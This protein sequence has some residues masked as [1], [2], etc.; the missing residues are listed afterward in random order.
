[1]LY[2]GKAK[3]LNKRVKNYSQ[4]N[5]LTPDKQQ[6]VNQAKQLKFQE[7][8]NEIEA[9]LTEAE[10]IRTYQP[11]FNILL[12]D[13]KSPLYIQITDEK[14][15]RVLQLRKTAL[16][17]A[18]NQRLIF[19][20]FS[21]GFM[22]TQVLKLARKI[23]PWCST[24]ESGKPCFYYHLQLCPGACCDKVTA[25]EYQQNISKL[26][27]FLRGQSQKLVRQLKAEM[28]QQSDLESYEAASRLKQQ[29]E[30]V[31]YVTQ[32]KYRLQPDWQTLALADDS[33][34][35]QLKYLSRL[36]K[37]HLGVPTQYSIERIEGYDVSN[38]SGTDATVSQ[39]TF[40]HGKETPSE[41]RLFNIR[42]VHQPNDYA[43][44][45]E[46][47]LRRQ[48]HPEW[49]RP[50]LIVVDGGKGQVRA[51]LKIWQWTSPVIG[52]AKDPDRL[53]FPKI[54][55]STKTN[56]PKQKI[57]WQVVGLD[58]RHPALQLVQAVRDAAHR[59][60]QRQYHRL[61]TKKMFKPAVSNRL[62]SAELSDEA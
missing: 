52:I 43:M 39:V 2:V 58:E 10:L 11:E 9:L 35:N 57:E 32:P 8:T 51:V 44:L 34:E 5:R 18:K 33:G 60:G 30:A 50:G 29:I 13:D 38:I 3:N 22:V 61:H 55:K 17:H 40:I 26:A 56:S 28:R 53:I 41:H 54:E 48:N 25:K 15:P 45:Q 47:L 16:L 14:F 20:P 42:S 62:N 27:L 23:F 36:L 37:I 19:G 59:F 4:I 31:E 7:L 24:P 12:K 46:A 21:S 49:G 6:L 1:M